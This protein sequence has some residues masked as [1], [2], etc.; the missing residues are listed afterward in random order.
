M[1]RQASGIV[2][3]PDEVIKRH[4]EKICKTRCVLEAGARSSVFKVLNISRRYPN[5]CGDILLS[6]L[7]LLPESFQ[8]LLQNHSNH[9]QKKLL[10]T[11]KMTC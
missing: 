2:A 5:G 1:S 8:T 10:D 9:L 4:V 3:P 6:N 7:S 11:K